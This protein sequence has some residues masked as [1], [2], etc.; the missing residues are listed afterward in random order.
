MTRDDIQENAVKLLQSENY[1][2]LS[3]STGTGKTR[4]A[5]LAI[6]ALKPKRTLIIVAERLH[7]E[8]WKKE[9]EKFG[10]SNLWNSITVECYASL[11]KYV[12]T[13]W[14]L[15]IMDEV[16]HAGSELRLSYLSTISTKRFLGLSATVTSKFVSTLSKTLK[17]SISLHNISLQE[18]IENDYLPEP[19][20]NVIPLTLN[21]TDINQEL[22]IEWGKKAL[23]K[24]IN[25]SFKDRWVYIR[26]KNIY[27]NVKLVIKCTEAQKH[28]YISDQFNFWEGKFMSTNNPKFKNLW[29]QWGLKRK[30]YLGELKT[31]YVKKLLSRI[32]DK[33]YICFCNSIAQAEELGGK[34]AIHS[35]KQDN[36]TIVKSFNEDKIKHLYAVG[37]AVE[38]MNLYGIEAGVIVQ[39]D[40]K[41]L[42]YYQKSGRV[43]RAEHPEQYIFCYKGTRDEQYLVKALEGLNTDYIK[44]Y[45]L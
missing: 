43:Y 7:K 41:P 8:N 15:L 14:D 33:K 6:D 35:N 40:G 23:R 42:R 11:H 24:T 13:S 22:V 17:H 26:N 10:Y 16:H 38:G 3:W 1:V 30:N 45:K 32:E 25:C 19:V 39:L 12:N 31:K 2:I 29:L 4:P 34:Y 28:L 5:I 36:E 21:T 44:E 9:F 18:S 37:M 27:P 20:I